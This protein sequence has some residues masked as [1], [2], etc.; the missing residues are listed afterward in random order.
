MAIA[1]LSQLTAESVTCQRARGHLHIV[2]GD[3]CSPKPACTATATPLTSAMPRCR[4]TS[5]TTRWRRCTTSSRGSTPAGAAGDPP[6]AP[7]PPP[8]RPRPWLRLDNVDEILL[9]DGEATSASGLSRRV[10]LV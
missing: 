2:D 1:P 10:P 7:P 6:D 5:T 9:I 8:K 3:P 4:S